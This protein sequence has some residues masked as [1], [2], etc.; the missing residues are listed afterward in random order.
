V[1]QLV[2]HLEKSIRLVKEKLELRRNLNEKKAIAARQFF[3]ITHAE[4]ERIEKEFWI[5]FEK[6]D[7]EEL[8]LF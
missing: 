6:E 4:I 8:E 1:H 3:E 2:E 7:E 5:K